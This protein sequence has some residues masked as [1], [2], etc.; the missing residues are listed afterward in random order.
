MLYDVCVDAP[1]ELELGPRSFA[2]AVC[3]ET[4]AFGRFRR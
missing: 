1:P 2:V 4:A 3:P